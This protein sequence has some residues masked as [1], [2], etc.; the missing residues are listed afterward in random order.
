[1]AGRGRPDAGSHERNQLAVM[2]ERRQR[3]VT[4]D[5]R[6]EENVAGESAAQAV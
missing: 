3:R 6:Q 1:M 2:A 4:D 5:A